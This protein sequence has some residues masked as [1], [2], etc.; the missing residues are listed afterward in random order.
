MKR[1][2]FCFFEDF[3]SGNLGN[4]WEFIGGNWSA[5]NYYLEAVG[6]TQNQIKRVLSSSESHVNLSSNRSLCYEYYTSDTFRYKNTGSFG[7]DNGTL[8]H[9]FRPYWEGKEKIYFNTNE[10]W[11]SSTIST[12]SWVQ[13]EMKQSG[14]N[15]TWYKDGSELTSFISEE[16]PSWSTAFYAYEHHDSNPAD[17]KI[18]NIIIKTYTHPEPTYSLGS[19]ESQ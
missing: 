14:N 7:L 6:S 9:Q 4:E 11:N 18:D 12:D 2:H 5:S 19:E 3:S 13:M 10:K 16:I 8:Y 17:L 1:I 15:V